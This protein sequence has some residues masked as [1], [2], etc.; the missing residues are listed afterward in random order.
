MGEL[1][2]LEAYRKVKHTERLGAALNYWEFKKR[3]NNKA[4]T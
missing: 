1:F 4:S 3:L 2:I